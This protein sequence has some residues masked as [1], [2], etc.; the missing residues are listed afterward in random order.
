MI[1]ALDGFEVLR[2][3]GKHAEVFA[4]VRGD[5]DKQARALVV[6]C[7]KAK[8]IGFD[9]LREVHNALGQEQFGLVLE[10]LKDAEVKTI[11]TRIDKHHPELKSGT[12]SWRREH[13]LELAKGSSAPSLPPTKPAK[14]AA[15]GQKS[16]AEGNKTKAEPPRLQSD[17]MDRF[18]KG[19]KD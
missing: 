17:V 16:R 4:V 19:G 11:L 10:G 5:V 2:R 15:A 9:A 7:L 18:R 8:S 14:K 3:L 1:L 12:V 6:K 13:L